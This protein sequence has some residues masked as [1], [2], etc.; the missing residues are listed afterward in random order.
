MYGKDSSQAVEVDNNA[1]KPARILDP[2]RFV[3]WNAER[4]QRRHASLG[5]AA[6]HCTVSLPPRV[7]LLLDAVTDSGGEVHLV[8]AE[9]TTSLQVFN[10]LCDEGVVHRVYLRI[11]PVD[12]TDQSRFTLEKMPCDCGVPTRDMMPC[13]HMVSV[14]IKVSLALALLVPYE[15][16]T[17]RW[18]EQ[19]PES[20]VAFV[21]TFADIVASD[22]VASDPDLRVPVAAPLK[23]GRPSHK[24]QRG[25]MERVAKKMY[26]G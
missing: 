16:T 12:S 23:R 8:Q 5:H 14:A 21:P 1:M 25:C 7:R 9:F 10:V 18:K 26:T 15:L 22:D 4:A 11:P 17:E 20:S 19:Y 24:R 6:R 3:L 2:I 13:R